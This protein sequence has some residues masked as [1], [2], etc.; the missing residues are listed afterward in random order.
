MNKIVRATVFFLFCCT[1]SYAQPYSIYQTLTT[2]NGLPSN[3]IFSVCQD[4]NGFLWV[5]TD[6]GVARYNGFN[7][8][9]WDKDNGLPGNYINQ[10]F[11][12]KRG[13]I[14]MQIGG[15]DFY[16]FN[17]LTATVTKIP[18]GI[19]VSKD[20]F[21]EQKISGKH[22]TNV[23][24]RPSGINASVQKIAEY[25]KDNT[26]NWY[27]D[28]GSKKI[29]SLITHGEDSVPQKKL[30]VAGWKLIFRM[31]PYDNN[32]RGIYLVNDSLIITNTEYYKYVNGK[33][34]TRLTLFRN[35]TYAFS[36]ATKTGCYITD[37]KTG[38][39]F[40]D[41]A[42]SKK[43]FNG[44]SGLGSDNVN[45]I[46]ELKDGTIAL[47]TLGAGLHFI[48]ND[49]KKSYLTGN[50]SVRTIQNWNGIWYILAGNNV[51]KIDGSKFNLSVLGVVPTPAFHLLKTADGV[52]ISSFKGIKFYKE[53]PMLQPYRSFFWNAGI[54]SMIKTK[55]SYLA[56]TYG[57]GVVDISDPKSTFK[58]S[59]SEMK[60]VEKM[61][62]LRSGYTLLSHEDGLI[63]VDTLSSKN[64]HITKENGLLSNSVFHVHE[65]NDTAWISAKKGINIWSR[66]K[67][68]KTISYDQGFSG[69]KAIYCFHDNKNQLWVVSDTYLHKLVKGRLQ[70][71]TS[72]PIIT[73]NDDVI[74]T[75]CYNAASNTL[76]IG[77]AKNI[78][79]ISLDKIMIDT[80]VVP[81]NLLQ[82]KVDDN[83][84]KNS[85]SLPYN[86][87]HLSFSFGPLTSS[88]LSP[89]KLFYRLQGKDEKW[90]QLQD[91]LT[92]SYTDLLPGSYHLNAKMINADGYKSGE[93][94]LASFIVHKPFWQTIWFFILLF[95]V[96]VALTI[97]SVKRIEN[98]KRK[99]KEAKQ[100][101]QQTLQ[102]ER[103]RISKDLHDHLGSNLVTML[104][105]IDNIETKLLKN[106]YSDITS[107]VQLLSYQAREVMNVLRETVWAVQENEHSLDEFLIRIKTFLQR[108]YESTEIIWGIKVE[109]NDPV[110]LSP[111]QT[112]QLFRILQEASQNIIKHS[113]ASEVVYEFI[114]QSDRLVISVI[115]NGCGLGNPS[116]KGGNG[117]AGI[118]QR[119]KEL[120]GTISF[121]INKGTSLFIEIPLKLSS[122]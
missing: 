61:L 39:Y 68:L 41:N 60:V 44:S 107:T 96:T 82:I 32:F 89:A 40:I 36:C 94:T 117:L 15:K 19:T 13:N 12:D 17:P 4:E 102:N 73:D 63:M 92:I 20:G 35:N 79:L 7:W 25:K 11:T 46:Y 53:N 24:F 111:K 30:F 83:F 64:I 5:G 80:S 49:F 115:D 55:N 2:T 98:A 87:H 45:Q 43:F 18:A 62:P 101:L 120:N 16:S 103:E 108:L 74:N 48:R 109:Q 26:I 78:S 71:I 56:A 14:C 52:L 100:L 112:L 50:K 72:N 69:N 66:G 76:A 97:L 113:K 28:V 27:Y 90:Y 33:L 116:Q 37:D 67:V 121:Q 42:G 8:Q 81:P 3:F 91:S 86:F 106:T 9:V 65:R 95:L 31:V 38:Y 75:A 59:S 118:L 47:A 110:C 99:N 70:A 85:F 22:T 104:A 1:S 6:K 93:K 105:Q 114:H 122:C 54:S 34:V 10:L 57:N 88:P 119:V 51:F 77:S 58:P 23:Y 21:F 29:V 84:E